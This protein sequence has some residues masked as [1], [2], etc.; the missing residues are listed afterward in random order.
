MRDKPDQISGFR[1]E[2]GDCMKLYDRFTSVL[3]EN[4]PDVLEAAQAHLN[5]PSKKQGSLWDQVADGSGAGG[6]SFDFGFNQEEE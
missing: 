1:M 4:V 5:S 3:R 2:H 6:F